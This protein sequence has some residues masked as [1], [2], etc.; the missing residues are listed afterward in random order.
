MVGAFR[1]VTATPMRRVRAAMRPV[2]DT[3]LTAWV[4][5]ELASVAFVMDY[6][7]LDCSASP[8]RWHV[9]TGSCLRFSATCPERFQQRDKANL[10]NGL[11]SDG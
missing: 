3:L 1:L 6:L 10:K 9:H 2:N 5:Q 7:Q 8:L 4:E 11:S